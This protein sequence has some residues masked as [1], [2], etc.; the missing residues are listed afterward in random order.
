MS[1][2]T[3][4][5]IP[6]VPTTI[7]DK[8]LRNHLQA[9]RD[10][11][12]T[13]AGQ[14]KN[15]LDYSPTVRELEAA[16]L[17]TL[18]AN[19]FAGNTNLGPIY[20]GNPP[21][22]GTYPSIPDAPTGVTVLA[23]PWFHHI[24]WDHPSE[25]SH[26]ITNHAEV[27]ASV[28]NDRNNAVLIGVSSLAMSIPV[29]PLATRY[30]W[31]RYISH[32][33][34]EG[35]W[36]NEYNDGVV[37][38]SAPDPATLLEVLSGAIT[39]SELYDV[40]NTRLDDYGVA[41]EQSE[42]S[43]V[44]KIDQYGHLA[45]Y[46]LMVNDPND[47]TT[48][49]P[50]LGDSTFG[51]SAST[52]WV[53]APGAVDFALIVDTGTN[54]VA[55]DGASIVSATITGAAIGTAAIDSAHIGAA[56]ITELHVED[57]AISDLK[58][59]DHIQSYTFD[60]ALG[61]GWLISKDGRIQASDIII[62]D[63]T[64][65]TI[66]AS[67]P[68]GAGYH[69]RIDNQAQLF[70]EISD[71]PD[72]LEYAALLSMP[73]G[74]YGDLKMTVDT[75]T[76]FAL[77]EGSRFF[78]P[79]G[80]RYTVEGGTYIDVF[81]RAGIAYGVAFVVY[82]TNALPAEWA[83]YNQHMSLCFYDETTKVWSMTAPGSGNQTAFSPNS[84]HCIIATSSR[85]TADGSDATFNSLISVNAALPDDY[86]TETG[87]SNLLI[88]ANFHGVANA[89]KAKGISPGVGASIDNNNPYWNPYSGR[90]EDVVW[91][92]SDEYGDYI[93]FLPET[94]PGADLGNINVEALLRLR[95][96]PGVLLYVTL[97]VD[98]KGTL[99]STHETWP[100]PRIHIT[101]DWYDSDSVWVEDSW[102]ITVDL[103]NNLGDGTQLFTGVTTAPPGAVEGKLK[104][105]QHPVGG[106]YTD[107]SFVGASY[108]PQEV[109]SDEAGTYIK[110]AA[111][112]TL[113]LAGNSVFV[114]SFTETTPEQVY[115]LSRGGPVDLLTGSVVVDNFTDSSSIL[116]SVSWWWS[117]GGS[118]NGN[119][120]NGLRPATYEW[121]LEARQNGGSWVNMIDKD[122]FLPISDFT[123]D[124][125]SDPTPLSFVAR[126][127]WMHWK[128]LLTPGGSSVPITYGFRFSHGP[129][130]FETDFGYAGQAKNIR[131]TLEAAQR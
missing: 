37:G 36:S 76:G 14:T 5:A 72:H 9:L 53:G 69:A 108:M 131:I 4:P 57:G 121:R 51:I 47:Q 103:Q 19:G 26:Y 99:T 15:R 106:I 13:R 125:S 120:S 91:L 122:E 12:Q 118:A 98:V 113:Q 7:K 54:R 25:E 116:I 77:V 73:G 74:G 10:A 32:T 126:A 81:H 39:E 21:P 111:I 35:P 16:G 65:E 43:Y 107:I 42:N 49:N 67:G 90:P 88:D 46:G 124:G 102:P 30:Y 129:S 85:A 50:A 61:V 127:G 87:H 68:S 27:W 100:N 29:E 86:A 115:S 93:R 128:Y 104:I 119:A 45:G 2:D 110:N 123:V 17:I 6:A 55:M 82:F 3:I 89:M 33:N 48:Y 117:W 8:Q 79:N 23:T 11:L 109:G 18:G 97:R 92:V 105:Y 78:L 130:S 1:K 22:G 71:V 52:F 94:A 59:G 56:V 75:G 95:V 112:D 44:V 101:L 96:T 84:T 66:L 20:P 34:V 114:S 62:R 58:I 24:S 63:N 60:P 80:S 38:I 40:L 41:V 70:A 64:G 28:D 83:G 31:V